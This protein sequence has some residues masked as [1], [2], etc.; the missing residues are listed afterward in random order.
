M[1]TITISVKNDDERKMILDFCRAKN[2]GATVQL[3][4]RFKTPKKIAKNFFGGEYINPKG[5]I[6]P[7]VA[8]DY[9]VK[10]LRRKNLIAENGRITL[11]DNL[12]RIF[13]RGEPVYL[14]DLPEM[15]E[16]IFEEHKE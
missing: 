1:A 4:T 7:S 8:F 12:T 2:I 3:D 11:D 14:T 13:D 10:Y 5:Q 16:G 15:V 6:P 9:I